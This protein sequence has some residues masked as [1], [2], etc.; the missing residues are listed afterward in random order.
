MGNVGTG[1]VL[2]FGILQHTT[3]CTHGIAGM[4]RY[5]TI[6]LI[7]IVFFREFIVSHCA[8][9]YGSASCMYNFTPYHQALSSHSHSSKTM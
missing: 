8:T 5:I 2:D 7:F 1:M 9:K 6:G 3:T 4:H